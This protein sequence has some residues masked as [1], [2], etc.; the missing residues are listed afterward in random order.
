[1]CINNAFAL[2]YGIGYLYYDSN[3]LNKLVYQSSSYLPSAFVLA[4]EFGHD[5][6]FAYGLTSPVSIS[7]ELGADCYAG[8]FAGH[9]A[10][11]NRITQNDI[12]AMIM[13]QCSGGDPQ[14]TPWW[15]QGAHGTCQQRVAAAL[16]GMTAH[17]QNIPPN[18][19][20]GL[21]VP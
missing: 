12:Q 9:L 11:Q 2:P 21:Y 8:Y 5:I 10:C 16:R 1:M 19:A 15:A 3:F 7:N 18:T 17:Q 13:Q 6:Q 14:G 20:C 4:H